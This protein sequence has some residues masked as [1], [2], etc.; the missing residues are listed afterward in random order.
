MS[1]ICLDTA[2]QWNDMENR[3]WCEDKKASISSNTESHSYGT[4]N[5][6]LSIQLF[7]VTIL[8][9]STH[10]LHTP[11]NSVFFSSSSFHHG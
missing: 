6:P 9:H 10:T 7:P 5:H 4:T 8:T 3:D 2:L 1:V 11:F